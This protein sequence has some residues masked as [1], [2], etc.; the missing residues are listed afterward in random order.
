[1][2]KEKKL[3]EAL[4]AFMEKGISPFLG[5]DHPSLHEWK[6]LK[7]ILEGDPIDSTQI[8]FYLLMANKSDAS[9]NKV[10]STSVN[11]LTS[12]SRGYDRNFQHGSTMRT[13]PLKVIES[14]GTDSRR[15][16]DNSSEKFC[17]TTW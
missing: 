2:E 14:K 10:K 5:E 9:E 13:S 4:K 17:L 7:G 11:K 8:D 12:S 15:Y 6:Y 3:V 1:M 16:V